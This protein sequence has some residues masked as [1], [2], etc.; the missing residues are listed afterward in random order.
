MTTQEAFRRQKEQS[1]LVLKNLQ[2][3]LEQG[4]DFGLFGINIDEDLS[5]LDK[6]REKS[7]KAS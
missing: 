5:K 7:P 6:A 1:E 3:F 4:K 2:R